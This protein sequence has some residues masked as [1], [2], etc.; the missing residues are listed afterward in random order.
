MLS[1]V[2]T[3]CLAILAGQAEGAGSLE[4]LRGAAATARDEV[5]RLKADQLA[6]RAE[7]SELSTRIEVLKAR[8]KGRLLRGSELDAALKK[9][10]ELSGVLTGLARQV[11]SSQAELDAASLA[12]FDGLLQEMTNLR[13]VLD[14][15]TDRAAR[16]G[17][18]TRLRELKVEREVVRLSLPPT[19]VPSIDRLKPTDDPDELLEQADLLR[20]NQEKVAKELKTLEVRIEQRRKEADLDRR[21]AR[22]LD[23][24][25]MFDD[26]D[27]RLRVERTTVTARTESAGPT[28]AG[29]APSSN[30]PGSSPT[31]VGPDVAPGSEYGG[32]AVQSA[33]ASDFAWQSYKTT[34]GSDANPQPAGARALDV[35]DEGLA[36]LEQERAK[37]KALSEELARKAAALEQQ[38]SQLR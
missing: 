35:G 4:A 20:D 27:R 3:L 17:L 9:S 18:L 32:T 15:E 25:S 28:S 16:R 14:H 19:E 13:G 5:G 26:Q 1:R 12:L 6:H 23:E 11:S 8:A 22:F 24:E 38:A 30:G 10:Q 2:A 33:G 36:R 29:G 7:L 31:R 34:T 21:V 37:L